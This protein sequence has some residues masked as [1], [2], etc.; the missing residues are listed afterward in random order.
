MPELSPI[1]PGTTALLLMDYQVD[2]LTRFM[3]AAQSGDAI[4]RVPD[5][6]ATAR[7]AGMVVIHVVVQFRPGHPEVSP[8]NSVFGGLKENGMM[9]AGSEGVAI[10]PAAAA[11]AGEPIVVKHRVSPFIGTDLETLLRANGVDTLVLAGVHTSGVVLSTVR[12]AADLDYRLVVVRDCCADPDAELHSMLLDRVIARQAAV[13]TT[14]EFAAMLR[15]VP[16]RS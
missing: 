7:D 12:H 13:V 2:A 6:I 9:A 4:A 1:D 16:T 3:T 8:R 11:R 10:H 15:S 5:L 14:A